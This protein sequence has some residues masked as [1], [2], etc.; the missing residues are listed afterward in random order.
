MSHKRKRSDALYSHYIDAFY[1]N[2]GFSN[3]A[4]TRNLASTNKSVTRNLD[5]TN[6]YIMTLFESESSSTFNQPNLIP[7]QSDPRPF[8]QPNLPD[9]SDPRP[10]DQP[11]PIPDQPD[12][13]LSINMTQPPTLTQPP[14]SNLISID[15]DSASASASTSTSTSTRVLPCTHCRSLDHLHYRCPKLPRVL[16]NRCYNCWRDIHKAKNCPN[17]RR[18]LNDVLRE[19]G[20][21]E[22][23]NN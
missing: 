5:A 9:Q 21:P 13:N 10:F 4:V 14:T 19:L 6:R 12:P 22:F 16:W 23:I 18:L 8:N 15:L 2:L 11:D 7:D 20:L 17:P 1:N 3:E